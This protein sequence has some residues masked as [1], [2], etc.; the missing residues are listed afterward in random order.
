MSGFSCLTCDT[1]VASQKHWQHRHACMVLVQNPVFAHMR[2][3]SILEMLELQ[4]SRIGLP[5]RPLLVYHNE[6]GPKEK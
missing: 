3:C 6:V 5:K 1:D 4:S 2:T